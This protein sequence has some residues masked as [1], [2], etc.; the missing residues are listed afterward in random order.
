MIDHV[1]GRKYSASKCFDH[2]HYVP[3]LKGK[4]GEFAALGWLSSAIASGLTPLI[5]FVEPPFSY[6]AQTPTKTLDE[7]LRNDAQRLVSGWGGNGRIFLDT[8]WIDAAAGAGGKHHLEYLFDE[9][10]GALD[11]VPVGGLT[12]GTAHEAAVAAIAAADGPGARTPA[13]T[14]RIL[15]IWACP[16]RPL[17]MIGLAPSGC[18]HETSTCSLTSVRFQ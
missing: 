6:K 2:R 14:P 8:I 3:I 11:A 13:L 15:P 9:C 5:E 17:S 16:W 7:H 18:R 4:G 10:R 1:T 12:R